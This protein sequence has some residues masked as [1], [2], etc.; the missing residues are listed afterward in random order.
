M[1][2]PVNEAAAEADL[3]WCHDRVQGVSRT[4]AITINLLEEPASS[5]ICVGYL[6]CRVADTVED[7]GHVPPSTKA[8]LLTRYERALD[9]EDPTEIDA[10]VDAVE[11]WVPDERTEDWEVVAAAPRVLRTFERFDADVQSAMRPPVLELVGGMVEFVERYADRGGL[12]IQTIEE[13]EEYCWYAAGTVGELI[14]NL[15][16]RNVAGER[17]R[18]MQDNAR[19]FALLLQ[20][21]NVA[22]DVEADYREE[23]NVYLPASW[24]R[25]QGVD[26]EEI[27]EPENVDD[28]TP[29]IRRV[30]DRASGYLDG[31]QT[32]L[33]AVPESDGNRL[34]A[35]AIPFLLAVGTIRE[36]RADPEAVLR[37]GGVKVSREE[38]VALVARF[39]QDVPRSALDDLRE[40]VA[41]EP[42]HHT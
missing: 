38:V 13:L 6:L 29:V 12:R 18:R 20:L 9:P 14:T 33:E 37:E 4:F 25:E 15:F 26:P 5:W 42:Y 21:V 35:W 7:A 39:G 36:L 11:P 27:C 24:I 3:A 40:A 8:S 22:K 23:D 31:A 32:Y 34:A 2:A 16:S 1:N 41:N 30:T 28:L 10:F 19:A 17:R